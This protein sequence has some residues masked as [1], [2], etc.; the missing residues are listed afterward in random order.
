MNKEK[1]KQ[2]HQHQ[3]EVLNYHLTKNDMLM[4]IRDK[5]GSPIAT[6]VALDMGDKVGVG[7]SALSPKEKC[8]VKK[9]GREIAIQRAV[10]Y[11]KKGV[12]KPRLPKQIMKN[13]ERFRLF[14][15]RL[16]TSERYKGK[17]LPEWITTEQY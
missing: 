7:F 2:K 14:V 12:V 1:R 3:E 4:Y 5:Q 15:D 6:L 11:T 9:Q 8:S 16:L 13:L 10:I 17:E